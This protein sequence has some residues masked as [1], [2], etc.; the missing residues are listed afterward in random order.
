MSDALL[1]STVN[2]TCDTCRRQQQQQVLNTS[3]AALVKECRDILSRAAAATGAQQQRSGT[4][5]CKQGVAVSTQPQVALD[6]MDAET[7]L[8]E[9][10]PHAT[11]KYEAAH[12]PRQAQC[13][14]NHTQQQ[15]YSGFALP[16]EAGPP[17]QLADVHDSQPQPEPRG[18]LC[19]S[20]PEI[21]TSFT[22]VSAADSQLTGT[23]TKENSVKQPSV[24]VSNTVVQQEPLS[25]APN[26]GGS[27]I[28]AL[29]QAMLTGEL[30]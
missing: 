10:L 14:A 17:A 4:E 11:L 23:T 25:V 29:L 2:R 15:I 27:S 9:V 20:S 13:S 21:V 7:Q 26:K 16:A 6:I 28:D 22:A 18:E 12:Q 19:N 24:S 30:A 1:A 3:D 8:L 5:K